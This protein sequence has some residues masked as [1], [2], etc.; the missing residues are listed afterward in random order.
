M[1]INPTFEPAL[2]DLGHC[3]IARGDYG[4][5]VAIFH[6][7]VA[8]SPN[9]ALAARDLANAYRNHERYDD[10]IRWFEASIKLDPTGVGA[11]NGLGNCHRETGNYTKAVPAY[12]AAV[13]LDPS[14][15]EILYNLAIVQVDLGR[16]DDALAVTEHALKEQPRAA[17]AHLAKGKAL[18]GLNRDEEALAAYEKGVEL[19]PTNVRG[20][21]LVAGMCGRLWQ[22]DKALTGYKRILEID[23]HHDQAFGLLVNEILSLGDWEVHRKFVATLLDRISAADPDPQFD[24][25]SIFNLQALPIRYDLI[26]K[27]ARRR[28]DRI[29]ESLSESL[30]SCAFTHDRTQRL[31]TGSGTMDRPRLGFVLPYTHRHSL[32]DALKPVIEQFDRDRFEVVGFSCRADDGGEFSRNYRAAFDHFTDVSTG[33]WGTVAQLIYDAEVDI[34]VDVSGHTPGNC[35]S[36][37]A[38]RPAPVQFHFLGYS[39]TTGSDFV[40]Y[41]IADH[42]YLTSE[43]AAAGSEAIAYLPD[44][45]MIT[46]H[47]SIPDLKISRTEFHLPD[48][49][50]VFSNFNHPASSNLKFLRPGCAS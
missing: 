32:P 7:V 45:F 5:A 9:S 20:L 18:A 6:R 8:L 12:E 27:A 46:S 29:L 34:L 14:N 35:L 48:D 49:G 10:A 1:A 43:C 41:L 13:A 4:E 26:A 38:L 17:L 19:D 30:D 33:T 22:T 31:G 21:M 36:A 47:P 50:I 16:F 40:D 3:L 2:T 39:I 15:A 42:T 11:L 24:N 44:S 23:P 28:S 25:V 37:L